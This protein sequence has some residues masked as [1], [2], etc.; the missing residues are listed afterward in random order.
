M[1]VPFVT[2]QALTE[3]MSGLSAR[4]RR[5][6]LR[7]VSAEADGIGLIRLL[8]TPYSCQFCGLRVG[9]TGMSR[10]TRKAALAA[11]EAGCEKRDKGRWK[12]VCGLSL[13]YRK[14]AKDPAFLDS[15][16]QARQEIAAGAM[17]QAVA[18]LQVGTPDAAME[19]HRQVKEGERDTDRRLAAVA[20]LDR[21]IDAPRTIRNLNIDVDL[22]R[23]T[24]EQL[25]RIAN[26]EDPIRVVLENPG[27][28]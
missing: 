26:G 7:I 2:S 22:S 12:F 13:Y 8:K 28:G 20:L 17:G 10:D 25:E 9:Q 18:I 1:D 24:V 14:W 19:L 16:G 4:Q 23:L 3:Q 15:L 6:I 21:V 27:A 5:A 11:H